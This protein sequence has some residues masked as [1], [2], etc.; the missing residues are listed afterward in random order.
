MVESALLLMER[1]DRARPLV[2]RGLAKLC[3]VKEG[4]MSVECLRGLSLLIQ[5]QEASGGGDRNADAADVLAEIVVPALKNKAD[6]EYLALA[7]LRGLGSMKPSRRLSEA[8]GG[9]ISLL[10]DLLQT[11]ATEETVYRVAS[12]ACMTQENCIEATG[13]GIPQAICQ[14]L[15]QTELPTEESGRQLYNDM[16]S[17]VGRCAWYVKK[18][19]LYMT[20]AKLHTEV[21]LYYMRDLIGEREKSTRLTVLQVT[22]G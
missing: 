6:D 13:Q 18:A 10:S 11:Y 20:K 12:I 8:L 9:C 19:A 5:Q 7:V 3:V 2:L 4:N 22:E 16:C 14:T 15:L 21:F 1:D 17:I